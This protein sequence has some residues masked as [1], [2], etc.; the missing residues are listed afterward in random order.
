MTKLRGLLARERGV[1]PE[2]N[3][4]TRTEMKEKEDL[5]AN[6]RELRGL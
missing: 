5:A 3:E 2:R 1:D 4:A 6:G